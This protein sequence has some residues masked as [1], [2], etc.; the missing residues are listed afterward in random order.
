M[1]G[2]YAFLVVCLLTLIGV[3]ANS[4]IQV[5]GQVTDRY[6]RPIPGVNVRIESTNIGVATDTDGRYQIVA[7]DDATL[8][9]SFIGYLPER[10]AINGRTTVD[11]MLIED[12]MDLDA[13]IVVGYGTVRKSDLTGSVA[14]VNMAAIQDIPANSVERLLQGRTAGLQVI[15][16]SQDPGAGSTIRIRGGSSLRGSNAPLIVVDGFPLGDAGDLK[17]INP[18]DIASIE[19]LKDASASAIYGSR[20]ANG[21]IMVTTRS[22]RAGETRVNISQQT[23][24]SRFTSKLIRWD[25]PLL[26]AMLTNEEMTNANRAIIYNGQ[27]NSQGTY[28]PSLD[29]I[30]T[31]AWPHNTRWDEVVFRETPISNNT[32]VSVNS[33]NETTSFNLSLNHLMENGVYIEDV[34]QKGIVKLDVNHIVNSFLTIRGSNLYSRNF[35]NSNGNL[36]YWRN[37]LWPVYDENGNYY[38]TSPTDFGHPLAQTNHVLNKNNGSD[39]IGT[40]LFDFKLHST[41]DFKSQ[42]NYKTGSWI[43]DRYDPKDYTEGGFFNNGHAQLNDWMDQ[44]ILTENYLTYNNLF[45]NEHRVTAMLGTSYEYWMERRSNMASFNFVN[46][47]LQNQNMAAGDPQRNT[48]SNSRS[49]TKL[50]SYMGRLNYSAW[51]KY[52]FTFTMRADGSSKFGANNRW[53]YF[54]S[55]AMSW[56]IHNEDF[57]K[58]LN[59]FNDLRLRLSYGKS[60]NQG[61]S[62]YQTLARYGVEKYFDDGAWR[63][64]IGPGY[65][66]GRGGADGRYV[67]WGGIPN[68]DLKWETTAQHNIGIDFAFLDSRIRVTA[69]Y[70][71]KTTTDLLRERLLPPSSSYDRM[72][73]NDGEVRNKGFEFTLYGDIV[74][75]RDFNVAATLIYSHNR[76]EVVS[77]GDELAS[78]LQTDPITGMKYEFVGYN[79]TQFRQT[80]NIL[81]MGQP[82][83]VFYGYKTDGIIQTLDEGLEAGLTGDLA[84]PGEFK[85]VDLN[86]DGVID[87]N[88]RTIIGDPNPDFVTS[89]ALNM[90]YKNFDLAVFLNGVFGNDVIYQGKLDQANVRPL[91]WTLDNPNNEYPRLFNGRQLRFSDWFI[92]DGSFVR[93]QNITLGYNFNLNAIKHVSN[94]RVYVNATDLYTFSK[95][96][97]YDPEVGI[98]G[99][100]WGGY[101]RFSRFTFGLNVTF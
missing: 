81:A 75:G 99:I 39:F 96:S 83:N 80:A 3:E 67:I 85:Y 27:V 43:L 90:N 9:F 101:P 18:A 89:F 45:A 61:I 49:E 46:E 73:I 6:G 25:D 88:D 1:K 86:T 55:G 76:N 94:L 21:V 28:F 35:R 42:V 78:G 84:Q 11:A 34:Y 10:I 91:R 38:R 7:A 72:W 64:V 95:F 97:G 2:L 79:F 77:L 63:T 31:G 14:T 74:R 71:D 65:E 24:L 12:I 58:N 100:Y 47:A 23:T 13:V 15:T 20:G 5:V 56:K 4:Q 48:H 87:V 60:G 98:E 66:I 19:V 36:A 30:Q 57:V 22:A 50:L 44:N 54:P 51:D 37:P 52:L 33:A 26:M 41:L 59:I 70:Y 16:S 8:Q 93:I 32:S 92:E 29:E 17:Q 82:I 53:A 40:Y 62:P 68:R 69:D